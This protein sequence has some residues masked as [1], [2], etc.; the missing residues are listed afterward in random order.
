MSDKPLSAPPPV[1]E[2]EGFLVLAPHPDDE[3]LGCG[4]LLATAFAQGSRAHVLILSDGARS[5]PNS[6]LWPPAR[7]A[8]LRREE[9]IEAVRRLGGT[10]EAISFLDYPD[11][12][13]PASG[14]RMIAAAGQ[15]L[16]RMR[17]LT[18]RT[19]L[20]TSPAD[21]HCDHLAAARIAREVAR[22]DV[23]IRL[24]FYPVWSRRSEQDLSEEGRYRLHRFPAGPHAATKRHALM[25]HQS[26]LGGLIT[27]DPSGFA[28]PPDFIETMLVEDE[29]YLE[30][31]H[32]HGDP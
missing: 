8:H 32:A 1:P 29:I 28:L 12:D 14:E 26:Q 18:L 2:E 6:R 31:I 21:P 22:R 3:T 4:A 19:L 16:E 15:T 25:A 23:G 11:C 17:T 27:D 10:R 5:H 20:V 30:P 7:L 13:V 24:L 9:A